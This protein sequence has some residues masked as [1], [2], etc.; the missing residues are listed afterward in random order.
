[1]KFTS[2]WYK[3]FVLA[4]PA[5]FFAGANCQANPLGVASGNMLAGLQYRQAGQQSTCSYNNAPSGGCSYT[6]STGFLPYNSSQGDQWTSI[7]ADL[8]ASIASSVDAQGL[9]AQAS[10]TVSNDPLDPALVHYWGSDVGGGTASVT[11][12]DMLTIGG[13]APAYLVIGYSL[14]GSLNAGGQG[15]ADIAESYSI[16][17]YTS[18]AG[19]SN[20]DLFSTISAYG[21]PL[22]GPQ[23]YLSY[24]PVTGGDQDSL[25]LQLQA[26]VSF[27]CQAF[28]PILCSSNASADAAHTL[29]FTQIGF[30]DGN[31][32]WITGNTIASANGF[33]YSVFNPANAGS[34]PE[35]GSMTYGMLL[36]TAGASWKFL[37]RRR[38]RPA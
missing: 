5:L 14:D 32:N 23:T 20:S 3:L 35:P 10:L 18:G 29:Q 24:I 4:A 13:S 12:S 9:H 30:Q 22:N 37:R 16:Y 38:Q 33:D 36:L 25:Y 7:T 15:R 31:G 11:W 27:G 17:D 6:N 21:P 28:T 2:G 1:M 19:D 8:S 34:A 26:R